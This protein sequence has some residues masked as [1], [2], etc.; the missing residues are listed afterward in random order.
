VP[1]TTML[2]T[3]ATGDPRTVLASEQATGKAQPFTTP[4]AITAGLLA[5]ALNGTDIVK[6]K[7][8]RDHKNGD[9]IT[10][11]PL[12]A[13]A[14]RVVND[15]FGLAAQQARGAWFLPEQ[16]SMKLG[17]LALPANLRNH[18]SHAIGIATDTV[19]RVEATT[20][21]DVLLAWALLIPLF[22][23]LMAPVMVRAVGSAGTP[24]EQRE[25]WAVI[26]E[27]YRS[28]GVEAALAPLAYRSGWARLDRAGQQQARLHLI[29]A[30]AAAD[31]PTLVASFRVTRLQALAAAF[32]KKAK[33]GTPLARQ[34]LTKALQPTLAA[35]FGGDWLAFLDYLDAHVN[36]A[37]QIITALP[38]T[39]LFTGAT[40]DT[41]A[42]AAQHGLDVDDVHAM[43]AAYMGQTTSVSPVDQR[44]AA[45]SRWW[46]GFD[47]A[48]ARQA[49]GMST[50][51]GVVDEGIYTVGNPRA[52]IPRLYRSVLSPDVVREI[53]SLWDGLTLPRWPERIVSEPHPHR[54]MAEAFGPALTFWNGVALTAWYV[55]EGP[56]SRT[57]LEGLA[58]YHHRQLTE[59]ADAGTPIDHALFTELVAAQ[60]RLGDPQPLNVRQDHQELITITISMGSRRDGFEI[61]RD[62]ITAH[63]RAWTT[64]H[65]STYL[66]HRWRTEVGSVAH[67]FHRSLAAT[68]KA[69]TL[70]QFAKFAAPAANHWFGGDLAGIYAA[71]GEKAPAT[72][73][74][75]DLLPV[76]AYEFAT[77][78]FT[79]IGG[80][81]FD[82][83]LASTDNPAYQRLWQLSKLAAA[84]SYFVQATEA[85]GRPPD[86]TEFN[87]E[88]YDWPWPGG[89]DQGWPIYANAIETL[90]TTP[91]EKFP[92]APT[93]TA[94]PSAAAIARQVP[95]N[96][97]I[98]AAVA[99]AAQQTAAAMAQVTTTQT[100][101][102]AA[103]ASTLPPAG[104][105]PD[106]T[107]EQIER[108]WDGTAWTASTRPRPQA[109]A[110]WYPDPHKKA[111]LRW[112]DGASWTEHT[113]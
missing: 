40:A 23:A 110:G 94:T 11:G 48:H 90:R 53:D 21:P 19:A 7:V 105:Y 45:M 31:L 33:A 69:P 71:L 30:L 50:L 34:V 28:L 41:A 16:L 4:D 26:T 81:P 27:Q 75:V 55:C 74:R 108:W 98:S 63:R 32:E 76:D 65:L 85:L 83:E 1:D 102:A 82:D 18:P 99:Q 61:L 70:R 57:P 104:W 80:H 14:R 29:D 58:D 5:A 106:A 39:R 47:A 44:V 49:P 64:Q 107:N 91:T 66:E 42:L 12:D 17:P 68:G 54:L 93:W 56:Y 60:S 8:D 67:E 46:S 100:R 13:H 72:P 35:Y 36:P 86:Q 24:D 25:T 96:A 15:T 3:L 97:P 37:E 10:L 79:A 22:D 113:S 59:L 84:S 101:P 95:A 62:I 73:A 78:V 103:T 38:Q 6:V 51:W 9:H 20:S 111:N 109:A 92:Q 43:L 88:R 89:L 77:A 87:A 2:H 112:W 52:A